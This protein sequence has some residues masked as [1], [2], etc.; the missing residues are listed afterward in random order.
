[1]IRKKILAVALTLAFTGVNAQ[2]NPANP[3]SHD[4]ASPIGLGGTNFATPLPANIATPARLVISSATAPNSCVMPPLFGGIIGN[5]QS[6]T[7]YQSPVVPYVANGCP[8]EVRT[9]NNTV[10]SGS[11]LYPSCYQQQ[12]LNCPLP[13]GGSLAMD[14]WVTAYNSTLVTYPATCTS[15]ARQCQDTM[16]G[17]QLSGS[18]AYQYSNCVQRINATCGSAN[19]VGSVS[20]PSSNLCSLGNNSAVTDSGSWNWTCNGVNG[21][22]NASCSAPK[23]LP[24]WVRHDWGNRPFSNPAVVAGCSAIYYDSNTFQYVGGCSYVP[25]NTCIGM[26]RLNPAENQ[27]TV[28]CEAH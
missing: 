8:S 3:A 12:A 4:S 27:G 22:S 20:A 24:V 18:A 26:T 14:A 13:W 9:C 23:V 1:M 25:L 15:Q 10:L 17:S 28:R 21:G 2:N 19:G 7:A 5:G 6:F 11:F 16:A